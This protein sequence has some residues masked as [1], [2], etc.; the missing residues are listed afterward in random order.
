MAEHSPQVTRE[1]FRN[2]VQQSDL[3]ARTMRIL[4]V[5]GFRITGYI[6]SNTLSFDYV[7]VSDGHTYEVWVEIQEDGTLE[8]SQCCCM[9]TCCRK[10]PCIHMNLF[11]WMQDGTIERISRPSE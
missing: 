10:R 2:A 5:G 6:D 7:D 4:P 3:D 1:D 11:S 9:D 8:P